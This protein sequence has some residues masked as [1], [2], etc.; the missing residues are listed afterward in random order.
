M[1]QSKPILGVVL[2]AALSVG[3]AHPANIKELST[4]QLE[5][6]NELGKEGGALDQ[7]KEQLV[8][9][10]DRDEA[11]LKEYLRES[12]LREEIVNVKREKPLFEEREDKVK[13]LQKGLELAE[14]KI[15]KEQTDLKDIK[16]EVLQRAE[17]MKTHAK[18]MHRMALKIHEYLH[19]DLA[20]KPAVEALMQEAAVLL[21]K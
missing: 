19:L 8:V 16:E 1:R 17:R 9:M 7:Y 15:A 12:H 2:V 5:L 14:M 3:C 18:T 6:I 11:I 21:S 20:D 13:D 4:K 10:L